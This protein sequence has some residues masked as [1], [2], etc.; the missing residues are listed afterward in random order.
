[1]L[2]NELLV[3]DPQAR[4]DLRGKALEEAMNELDAFIDQALLNNM[5]Q[6]ISSMVSEQVL[7]V[8]VSPNTYK[9][10]NMSRVSA[11]PHKMLEAVVRLLWPFKG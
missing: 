7:S 11:M 3:V 6:L 4:L 8:K 5:A 1:M 10:T 2:W 9:E